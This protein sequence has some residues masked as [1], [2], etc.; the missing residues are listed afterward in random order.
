M[1]T[2]TRFANDQ[3]GAAA[4]EYG[5][6]AT[7]N[8]VRIVAAATTPGGSLPGLLTRISHKLNTAT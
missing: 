7:L 6:I 3:S 5:P 2:A 8:T 1:N 4:M